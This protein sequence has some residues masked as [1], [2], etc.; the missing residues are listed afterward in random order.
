M[1]GK[2]DDAAT[3]GERHHKNHFDNSITKETR[4]EA[5]ITRPVTRAADVL[6]VLGDG[7]MTA[8]EIANK[9]GFVERNAAAPRLSEMKDRGIVEVVGKKKDGVTGKNVALWKKVE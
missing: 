4:Q 2:K 5:Y 6:R 9:L 1:V 3:R 8:R 7:E